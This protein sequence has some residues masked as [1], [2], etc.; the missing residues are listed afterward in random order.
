MAGLLNTFAS[1]QEGPENWEKGNT[2]GADSGCVDQEA[3]WVGG[4]IQA[5]AALNCNVTV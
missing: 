2:A 4:S 3:D 5:S 1:D